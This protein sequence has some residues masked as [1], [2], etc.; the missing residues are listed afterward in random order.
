M[1]EITLK[2]CPFCGGEAHFGKTSYSKPLEDTVWHDDGAPV[3]EAHFVSC[4]SCTASNRNSLAGGCR[5]QERAA[6]SWNTRQAEA[7]VEGLPKDIAL[8]VAKMGKVEW[9]AVQPKPDEDHA[10]SFADSLKLTRE[11]F[12]TEG[13]QSLHGVYLEG[14]EIVLCHTGTSPNSANNARA[15]TG[16]WNWLVDQ[17]T[18]LSHNPHA[19]EGAEA[20]DSRIFSRASGRNSEGSGGVYGEQV[21]QSREPNP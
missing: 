1:T 14:T 7:K 2:P 5:T 16:A 4:V 21:V 18:H 6:E 11:Y 12:K 15:L 20:P 10:K 3:T 13:D 8:A 17:A 19:D 9:G